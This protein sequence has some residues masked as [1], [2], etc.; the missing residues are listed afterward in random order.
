M[1]EELQRLADAGGPE[2]DL[3]LDSLGIARAPPPRPKV[4]A[5]KGKEG[6][7]VYS[8]DKAY[9]KALAKELLP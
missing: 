7:I 3:V 4:Y 2:A 6:A 1:R 5:V 9:A 8:S